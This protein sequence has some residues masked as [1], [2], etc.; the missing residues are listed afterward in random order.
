MSYLK[1]RAIGYL[2]LPVV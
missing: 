2:K 1:S